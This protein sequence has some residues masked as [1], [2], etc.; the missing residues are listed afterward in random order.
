MLPMTAGFLVMGPASGYLSDK[1]GPR[2]FMVFGM[3]IVTISFLWLAFMPYDVDYVF[4]A[5]A[6]FFQGIGAGMFASPNISLIMSSVPAETRGVAS[7]MRATIQNVA[8]SL[9]MT[10][11]FAILIVALEI[12]FLGT[13]LSKVPASAALFSIFLGIAPPGVTVST[14]TKIFAPIFME[15]LSLLL[16]ISAALSIIAAVFSVMTK[17][18]GKRNN[19]S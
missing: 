18:K 17:S 8:N 5:I 2:L 16:I 7:G 13:T 15:S 14:F 9:S 10:I 19:S 12:H 11:Y 1:Y 3:I 6:I 4:L